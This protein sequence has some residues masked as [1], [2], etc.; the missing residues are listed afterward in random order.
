M[1]SDDTPATLLQAVRDEAVEYL[2][3]PVDPPAVVQLVRQV[4]ERPAPR[5]IEVVS[6]RPE[7]VELV[8]PCTREAVE[9]VHGVVAHLDA[10]L[11]ADA[12]EAIA[13]AFRELLMNAVEW[14]GK[15]DPKRTVRISY[16]RAQ[17]MVL[18]RIADPG[19]GFR[20]EDLDHAAITH[21]DD[22][23]E[24]VAIRDRKGLR[25]GGFGLVMVRATVDELIYNEKRNEVVFIKYL[26]PSSRRLT[27]VPHEL[28]TNL[29]SSAQISSPDACLRHV[30]HRLSGSWHADCT[31][32]APVCRRPR[33]VI[34]SPIGTEG[35]LLADWLTSEGFDPVKAVTP[36]GALAAITARPH[37]LLIAD[38]GMAFKDGLEAASRPYRRNPATPAIVI[39]D[40]ASMQ[41]QAEVRGAMYLGRPVDREML[42]CSITMAT[43]DERPVRRS[44]RKLVDRFDAI[45][46]GTRSHI[47]D[48]SPEG[49]RLEIPSDRRS[50][51][52][53]YFSVR[54][55][56]IGVALIV[57]RMWA[58]R[59]SASAV[60]VRRRARAQLVQGR[61]GLA[62][63]RRRDSAQRTAVEQLR[64]PLSAPRRR[65]G[66]RAV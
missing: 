13:Y 28:I 57:Q 37:D 52:P 10:D 34:A 58:A 42:M 48:V 64:D 41:A 4:L 62:G 15:L 1:T 55:P 39:G 63:L 8:V 56:M 44:P 43:M 21:P 18:Y 19:T 6:A 7:W 65:R 59:R 2:R 31:G 27:D 22:P 40:S 30:L 11:P 25:P 38:A 23:V 36:G 60:V 66:S 45:V 5:P 12:R 46:D 29:P 35:E 53:P 26:D 47:I 14:G 32:A 17:R 54:V 9:R 51:P 16:L 33:V 61:A 49:L 50:S 3:K 20:L 24:H